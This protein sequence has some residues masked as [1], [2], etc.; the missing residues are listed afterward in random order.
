MAVRSRDYYRACCGCCHVH[1]ATFVLTF[2]LLFLSVLGIG[3]S[4]AKAQQ[5]GEGYWALGVGALGIVALGFVLL[6]SI[7]KNHILYLPA[8][9]ITVFQLLFLA[10]V[11]VL[12][13][14]AIVALSRETDDKDK[15]AKI[16]ALVVAEVVAGITFVLQLVYLSCFLWKDYLYVKNEL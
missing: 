12:W 16:V 8:I 5:T 15:T 13:V 3:T 6:G 7:L 14:V 9:V 10:V 4:I 1:S 11:M 2:F